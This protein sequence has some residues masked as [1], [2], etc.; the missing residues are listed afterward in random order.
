MQ[1]DTHIIKIGNRSGACGGQRET[2]REGEIR[3]NAER[4]QRKPKRERE[5]ERAAGARIVS[6]YKWLCDMC[7]KAENVGNHWEICVEISVC[8]S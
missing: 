4:A 7:E 2:E 8:S 3:G 5:G 6:D 1:R